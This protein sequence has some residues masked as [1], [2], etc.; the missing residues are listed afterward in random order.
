MVI[1]LTG[2]NR[3]KVKSELNRQINEFVK[4]HG[5]LSIERFDSSE[6]ETEQ[7][8]N[9]AVA[10]SLFND[11]KLVVIESFEANKT[12]TDQLETLLNQAPDETTVVLVIDK[13]DKR[14][15]YIK[16]L[17]EQ[18]D[19]RDFSSLS[20]DETIAWLVQAAKEKG[21]SLDR[22]SA[23]HLIDFVGTDQLRLSNELD[24][25]VLFNPKVTRQ[26][27]DQLTEPQP[28]TT[29]FELLEAGFKGRQEKALSIYDDQRRQRVEPI[30]I[31]SMIGWQLHIL[32]VVKTAKQ[33][34]ASEIAKA[35]GLHP[36][37]VQKSLGLAR[38]MSLAKLKSLVRQAVQ[39]EVMLKTRTVD[40]DDA[41]KQFLLSLTTS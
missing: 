37:V 26:T 27:I 20:P 31:M 38:D 13:L 6:H 5:P 9:A 39:L 4:A 17:K 10:S 23:Q 35:A 14:A 25:L 36:F 22:A 41:L 21:G 32:A 16:T 12:L 7:I 29:V 15:A 1:T 40:A 24:K 28:S 33:K 11:Q 2:D 8:L 30:Y 19:W 18:S 3:H 34:S